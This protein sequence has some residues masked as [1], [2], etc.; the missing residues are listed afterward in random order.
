MRKAWA[1]QAQPAGKSAQPKELKRLLRKI[2]AERA[3]GRSLVA[4]LV[5]ADY[6]A[7]RLGIDPE[8]LLRPM[9]PS[10]NLSVDAG[11]LPTVSAVI[12]K[13]K[14]MLMPR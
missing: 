4:K 3:K 5:L 13:R 1:K 7:A 9:R 8:E 11:Y 6:N 12:A 14:P 2:E 10:Q